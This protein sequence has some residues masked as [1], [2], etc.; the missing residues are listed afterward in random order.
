MKRL[1]ANIENLINDK[2]I[3]TKWSE[4]E[5]H[6]AS[7]FLNLLF[8]EQVEYGNLA[9]AIVVENRVV[10]VNLYEGVPYNAAEG[11]EMVIRMYIDTED[12]ILFLCR[13]GNLYLYETEGM[14][15]EDLRHY[16]GKD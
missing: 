16:Y 1:D 8:Q 9:Q 14:D 3:K 2:K 5:C 15:S 7:E 12:N 10:C 11:Q 6:G 13:S 4:L